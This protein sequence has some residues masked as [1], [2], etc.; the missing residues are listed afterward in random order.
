MVYWDL[1]LSGLVLVFF[2]LLA[3]LILWPH[4]ESWVPLELQAG[5][6]DPGTVRPD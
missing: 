2:G 1:I 5:E 6:D 3:W 4:G